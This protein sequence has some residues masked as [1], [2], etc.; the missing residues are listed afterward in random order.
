MSAR[1]VLVDL[2]LWEVTPSV[3]GALEAR[4]TSK[5]RHRSAALETCLGT[6]GAQQV[7]IA[8]PR[9]DAHLEPGARLAAICTTYRP[10][11]FVAVG[12]SVGPERGCSVLRTADDIS[13]YSATWP[14]TLWQ[15]ASRHDV[16]IE[17][18]AVTATKEELA[19]VVD[20]PTMARRL[21]RFV[22]GWGRGAGVMKREVELREQLR[23]RA[24]DAVQS[25]L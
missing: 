17:V 25:L 4:L 24:A 10:K 9:A 2:A 11:R 7:L 14:G 16:P 8:K 1:H 23:T 15:A 20:Q 3:L 22:G 13:T 5:R 12:A 6:L 18:I 19:A 21:G